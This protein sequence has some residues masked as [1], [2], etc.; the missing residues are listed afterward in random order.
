MHAES[1][2]E[3][4]EVEGALARGWESVAAG[5]SAIVNVVLSR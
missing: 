3:P 5:R 4:A 2:S 1:V